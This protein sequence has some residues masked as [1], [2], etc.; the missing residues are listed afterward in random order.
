VVTYI[1]SLNAGLCCHR[2]YVT[3]KRHVT[4]RQ[5][6]SAQKEKTEFVP[7]FPDDSAF[8][9]FPDQNLPGFSFVAFLQIL[10]IFLTNKTV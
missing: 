2:K 6:K 1:N 5:R 10:P 8:F 3:K 7:R 4:I 9:L